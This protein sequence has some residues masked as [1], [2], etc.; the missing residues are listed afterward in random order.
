M[1]DVQDTDAKKSNEHLPIGE[2]HPQLY[3]KARV[4]TP[5]FWWMIAWWYHDSHWGEEGTIIRVEWN[6]QRGET[7]YTLLFG[8]SDRGVRKDYVGRELEFLD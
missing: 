8:S 4:R 2:Y 3:K 7:L 5:R 6:V 1:N